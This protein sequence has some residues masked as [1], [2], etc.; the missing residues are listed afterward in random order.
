MR[1]SSLILTEQARLAPLNN[2]SNTR[3]LF[4]FRYTSKHQPVPTPPR[5]V[6]LL[7][8]YISV[9]CYSPLPNLIVFSLFETHPPVLKN[10]HPTTSL[11]PETRSISVTG[12]DSSDNSARTPNPSC[13]DFVDL[14]TVSARLQPLSSYPSSL[15]LEADNCLPHPS[16]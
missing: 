14:C 1:L 2:F 9:L 12:L 11:S 10:I 5:T 15:V 4:H 13:R 8:N 7:W 3:D 6:L 16:Q